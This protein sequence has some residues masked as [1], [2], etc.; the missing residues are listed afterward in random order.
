MVCAWEYCDI[1]FGL[2]G[3]LTIDRVL[4]KMV[5]VL[6]DTLPTLVLLGHNVPELPSVLNQW[7]GLPKHA[8]KMMQGWLPEREHGG[9][10]QRQH[11]G[12]KIGVM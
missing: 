5:V 12:L 7:E 8:V 6:S 1:P 3:E 2:G 11:S 10:Q 4:V 9:L